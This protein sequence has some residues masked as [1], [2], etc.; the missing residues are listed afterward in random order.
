MLIWDWETTSSL[1][2]ALQL[3]SPLFSIIKFSQPKIKK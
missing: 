2:H 1:S 3:V